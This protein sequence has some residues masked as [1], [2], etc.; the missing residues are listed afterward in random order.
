MAE[1]AR[2]WSLCKPLFVDHWETCQRAQPRYQTA[3][4]DGLVAKRL[5]CG[6]PAKIGDL[7]YRCLHCG[8]GQP[9]V[10]MRCTSSL[11]LRCATVSVDNWVSQVSQILHA[12]VLDRPIIL[13]VPAMLR[14]TFYQHAAGMLSACRRCG[15]RCLDDFSSEVRGKA[16]RGGSSV[17]LH[18]QGRHGQYHPHLHVLATRGGDD[19]QGQRWEPLQSLP[20]DLR[21]RTW[22][23]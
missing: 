12:G 15:A 6:N 3:Y 10:A 18:T 8:Q 9:L 2:D 14:T 11:G 19:G 4:Y 21:R 1:S 23:W 20:Y 5:A 17:V 7:A 22:P 16:L 13:T